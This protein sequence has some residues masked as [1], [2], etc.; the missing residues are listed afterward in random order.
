MASNIHTAPSWGQGLADT[1]YIYVDAGD[2]NTYTTGISTWR[3]PTTYNWYSGGADTITIDGT[4]TDLFVQGGMTVGG[5]IISEEFEKRIKEEMMVQVQ[6]YISGLIPMIISMATERWI[7][8]L[9][10]A[11]RFTNGV[12]CFNCGAAIVRGKEQEVCDFCGR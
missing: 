10:Q 6:Q 4:S 11:K 12:F 8:I 2:T 5:D 1:S 7:P 3:V 9:G